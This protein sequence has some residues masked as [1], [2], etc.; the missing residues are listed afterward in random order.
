MSRNGIRD[1]AAPWS[2]FLPVTL[3]VVAGVLVAGW[4]QRGIDK[5][6]GEDDRRAA[7]AGPA[8]DGE[9]PS[10]AGEHAG[11]DGRAPEIVPAAAAPRKEAAPPA[12]PPRA[13]E[14]ASPAEAATALAAAAPAAEALPALPGAILARR[15]GAPEACIHGTIATRDSNGWQQKLENDAPVRCVEQAV[16]PR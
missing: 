2:F 15:D 6:F 16:V 1:E 14:S 12:A 9:A 7:Q 8:R 3:A 11:P 4:V 5:V 10:R 13:A